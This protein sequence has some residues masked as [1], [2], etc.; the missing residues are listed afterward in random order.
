MKIKRIIILF[1][2]LILATKACYANEITLKT[3]EEL[4][5]NSNINIKIA[6]NLGE[7]EEN[8]HFLQGKLE[9]D[10]NIFEK[11]KPEDIELLNG[12]H[13][14][15]FNAENGTF[16]IEGIEASKNDL[17]DIMN[18][19][20]KTKNNIEKNTT[21]IKLKNIKELGE[22]QIE[23]E[24]EETTIV[25]SKPTKDNLANRIIPFTG[26]G[27]IITYGIIIIISVIVIILIK[28]KKQTETRKED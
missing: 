22:S 8:I 27:Y 20:M 16:V 21:T 3:G 4:K 5:E 9:Y 1:C 18:I 28:K 17:Q 10:T 24:L 23:K 25:I 19:K 13:D 7:I 14:L 2:V 12:W 15:V 6:I 11:V 26:A